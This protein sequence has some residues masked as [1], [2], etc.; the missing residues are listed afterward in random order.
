MSWTSLWSILPVRHSVLETVPLAEEDLVVVVSP[1]HRFARRRRLRVQDLDGVPLVMPHEGYD[2]RTTVI[3]ACRQAGFE[4]AVACD[5]GELGGVLALVASGLGAAV[6]PSIVASHQRGLHV[7][8][9]AEPRLMR[10]IGIA[11]RAGAVVPASVAAFAAEVFTLLHGVDWPGV[12]PAGLRLAAGADANSWAAQI[13]SGSSPATSR[14]RE[15][16]L[17]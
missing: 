17:T 4:P 14:G 1:G 11:R 12:R 15:A 9:V 2:L 7:V 8:R 16:T 5:G 10:T 13:R 6:V 3:A